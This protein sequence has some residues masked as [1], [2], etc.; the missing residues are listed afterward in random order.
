MPLGSKV[1]WRFFDTDSHN[2]TFANGPRAFSSLDTRRGGAYAYRFR[3]RGLYKL[4][5][6]LH[7]VAMTQTVRVR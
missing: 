3:E 4:M 2:I 1:R 6:G 7:P 5:C